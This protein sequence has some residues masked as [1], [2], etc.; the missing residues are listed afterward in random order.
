[1]PSD[2]SSPLFSIVIP[3]YNRPELLHRALLSC[4]SQ[5]YTNFET[6]VVDDGSTES[7]HDAIDS[8]NDSRIKLHRQKNAG[9]SAARN[10]GISLAKGKWICLLDSDDYFYPEKLEKVESV[11]KSQ[12]A[13]FIF[14]KASI[15]RGLSSVWPTPQ[16][17]LKDNDE[18][19]E[20]MFSK[21]QVIPTST[22]VIKSSVAREIRFDES[23]AIGEDID[24]I[25]RIA[26]KGKK[27]LMIP[28]VLSVYDDSGGIERTSRKNTGATLDL[29]LEENRCYF[30]VKGYYGFRASYLSK[31]LGGKQ[32]LQTLK[33]LYLGYS[34]GGL[35]ISL[36]L[37]RALRAYFPRVYDSVVAAFLNTNSKL[38]P[39]K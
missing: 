32:P 18:L 39:K 38:A 35:S 10:T 13:D 23:L 4:T 27:L 16:L 26:G 33:D 11:V 37:R 1:M 14:S 5:T 29:W 28:D 22:F 17:V 25:V 31:H 3:C 8:I 34:K 9:G 30:S 20:F 2:N 36:V 7:L 12:H 24:Y 21:Y 19:T 15:D 6:I